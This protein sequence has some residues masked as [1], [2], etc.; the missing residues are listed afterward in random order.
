MVLEIDVEDYLHNLMATKPPY[1]CPYEQCGKTYK[2]YQGISYHLCNQHGGDGDRAA[3]G[4]GG[5]KKGSRNRSPSG[6]D[7][8]SATREALTYAEAQR[9]IEVEIDGRTH[10]ININEPLNILKDDM[11]LKFNGVVKDGVSEEKSD[12][13]SS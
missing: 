7:Y 12:T 10:R 6:S 9:M 8:G 4:D 11:S 1:T 2:S 5:R 13:V 3:T